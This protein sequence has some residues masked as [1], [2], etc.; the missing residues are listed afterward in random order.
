MGK[1]E[2]LLLLAGAMLAGI[3]IWRQNQLQQWESDP[4]RTAVGLRQLA[5][6]FTLADHNR[7]VVK[8]ERLLGR[9]R[10][11]LVFFD[12]ELGVDRDPRTRIL[13]DNFEKLD[14]S[15]IEVIA[16]ST[17]TP[18]ANGEAEKRLGSKVPFPVLTDIEINDPQPTPAHR[19]YGLVTEQT[20][21]L[22]TGIFL[23]ERDGS[24]PFSASG[25]PRRVKNETLLL[26][27]LSQG[28]WPGA[29]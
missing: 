20:Q 22:Q 2:I 15:G 13:I 19:K 28:Q 7:K 17:A 11:V 29:N 23:I 21:E 16:V 3:V 6:R 25:S 26:G 5:P 1:R 24:I 8:L 10:I 14:Q 27:D 9:H 18:F 12:A 4:S